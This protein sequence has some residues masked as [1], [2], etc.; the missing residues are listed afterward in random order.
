[1]PI[2]R[3]PT[4]DFID[5]KQRNRLDSLITDSTPNAAPEV[6]AKV[7]ELVNV[8]FDENPNLFDPTDIERFRTSDWTVTRFLLR[9]QNNAEEA[10][11]M[12][13]SCA[14]WRHRLG[15]PQWKDSDFPREFY[16]LGGVFPYAQDLLGNTVI[17][18]RAK[19]YDKKLTCIQ[20]LFQRYII[21][22]ANRVDNE[23][24]GRGWAI[25]FDCS[26]LGFANMDINMLLF[27]LNEVIPHLPK[28]L[29]YVLIYELPWLLSKIVNTTI[30]CLPLEYKKLA[31]T[32]NK[33][34]ISNWISQ[35]CLPDFMN[36]TCDI[37][38]RRAPKDSKSFEEMA[39]ELKL[40]ERD[41]NAIKKIYQ[42]YLDEADEALEQRD[43]MTKNMMRRRSSVLEFWHWMKNKTSSAS[44]SDD[45]N[46]PRTSAA[47]AQAEQ[48][49]HSATSTS[50]A[51]AEPD[52][53]PL[54]KKISAS[55]RDG[56]KLEVIEDERDD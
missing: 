8:Q 27:M 32:A 2:N 5:V 35:D 33:K 13:I 10:A 24:D 22:I 54:S 25:V 7:R 46:Q 48:S 53:K 56:P 18:I 41:L 3:M 36:G 12:I 11:K 38:Y 1:M 47:A 34:D 14:K 55:K 17:Y 6:I 15:M 20:D 16:N 37:N 28:G 45:P 21:H 51:S 52:Q 4:K 30:A 44:T 39:T 23:R 9:K 31:K 42:P 19:L 50:S 40:S 43:K 29:N 49:T 26:G